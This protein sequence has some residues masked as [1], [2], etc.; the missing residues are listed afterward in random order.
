[1]NSDR[2]FE[3]PSLSCVDLFLSATELVFLSFLLRK[4][5]LCLNDGV[6]CQR[7]DS[8]TLVVPTD[9]VFTRLLPLCERQLNDGGERLSDFP[10]PETPPAALVTTA[11]RS[12]PRRARL[13]LTFESCGSLI[14]GCLGLYFAS[15]LFL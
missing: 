5:D 11:R 14:V 1:M 8:E 2:S 10:R 13:V 6:N 3:A 15:V 9:Y 12:E 7:L 4:S